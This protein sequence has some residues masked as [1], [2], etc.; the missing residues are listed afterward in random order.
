VIL[1]MLM[2]P[3]TGWTAPTLVAEISRYRRCHHMCTVRGSLFTCT[4]FVGFEI[5][6]RFINI[7]QFEAGICSSGR[8]LHKF[9]KAQLFVMTVLPLPLFSDRTGCLT[10][11]SVS[12]KQPN[13]I[14]IICGNTLSYCHHSNV[15]NLHKYHMLVKIFTSI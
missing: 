2:M 14:C 8:L 7:W 11:L 5:S 1:A 3:C 4:N 12:C 15:S 10:G 6:D 9:R 13:K